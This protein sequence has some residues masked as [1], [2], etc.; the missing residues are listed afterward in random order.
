MELPHDLFY[1]IAIG[2]AEQRVDGALG[3]ARGVNASSLPTGLGVPPAVS[4]ATVHGAECF[5]AP[6]ARG[7]SA[8]ETQAD[9]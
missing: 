1:S 5:T 3:M 6:L 4:S 8:N 2:F 7:W 9:A